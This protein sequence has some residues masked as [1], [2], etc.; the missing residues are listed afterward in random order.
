MHTAQQSKAD[1]TLWTPF[2]SDSQLNW[3]Q[4]LLLLI[5]ITQD[6]RKENKNVRY[7]SYADPQSIFTL[8]ASV[9]LKYDSFLPAIAQKKNCSQQ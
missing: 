5:L 3:L 2:L 8:P 1:S 6:Y 7:K 9:A 4:F